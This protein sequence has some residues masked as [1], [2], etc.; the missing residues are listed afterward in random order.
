MSKLNVGLLGN[1]GLLLFVL[2]SAILAGCYPSHPQS[3]F[4]TLGPVSRSQLSLFYWIFW[5]AVIVFVVVVSALIYALIR[6]RRKPEDGDP[7]Q[8]HGHTKLEIIW[9]ILPAIILAVIAVP[10]VITVFDNANSP[11]SPAEG[12]MEVDAQKY[13]DQRDQRDA[14]LRLNRIYKR[15]N[16]LGQIHRFVVPDIVHRVWN[17]VDTTVAHGFGS[18]FHHLPSRYCEV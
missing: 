9:T 17:P 1:I 13:L 3:T 18:N 2:V 7:P 12:G 11:K 5:A 15:T 10:T 8:I 14:P 4:D 16:S 6:Y